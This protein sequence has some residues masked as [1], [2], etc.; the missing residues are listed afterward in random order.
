M[1]TTAQVPHEFCGLCQGHIV[2]GA[3]DLATF[4]RRFSKFPFLVSGGSVGLCG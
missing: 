3:S 4:V 1:A 2:L